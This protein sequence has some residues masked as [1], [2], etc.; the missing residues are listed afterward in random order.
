MTNNGSTKTELKLGLL[1]LNPVDNVFVKITDY[2]T[3]YRDKID[4][5]ILPELFNTGFNKELTFIKAKSSEGVIVIKRLREVAK[6]YNIAIAGSTLFTEGGAFRNKGFI[7]KK[8]GCV[9]Y[10]DKRHLFCKSPES[11]MLKAGKEHPAIVEIDGRKIC[12]VICYD[13]RFPVWCRQRGIE[14][15]YDLLIVVANWP[16]VRDYAWTQLLIARAIENQAF[17]AGV[18]RT[19][20]DEY[21]EYS[22]EMNE[23]FDSKGKAVKL[24]IDGELSVGTI[25]L[26]ELKTHRYHWPLIADADD[27]DIVL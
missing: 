10:Y 2:L 19:G 5:L 18:N 1:S 15:M 6:Q 17:V 22:S 24:Y 20:S 8:D 27:Y 7:I 26:D 16:K 3:R 9:T 13:L 25:N 4:I 21:G 11:S 12:L 23:I 14:N